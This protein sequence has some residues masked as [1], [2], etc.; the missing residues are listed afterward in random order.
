MNSTR[1]TR[2]VIRHIFNRSSLPFIAI[3][4]MYK[5]YGMEHRLSLLNIQA[6]RARLRG[7][8]AQT[9]HIDI[10]Y[11]VLIP[12]LTDEINGKPRGNGTAGNGQ[13]GKIFFRSN[14]FMQETTID[15]IKQYVSNTA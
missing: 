12:L 4:L 11:V 10:F 9:L 8:F 14:R 13:A 15:H 3:R 5:L 1:K 6:L 2:L 7:L